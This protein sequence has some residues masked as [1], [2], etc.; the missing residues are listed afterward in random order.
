MQIASLDLCKD[1]Y[2]LSGWID[3]YLTYHLDVRSNEWCEP[4]HSEVFEHVLISLAE[5]KSTYKKDRV[6]PAY[7]LGYLL[8]KLPYGGFCLQRHPDPDGGWQA[9]LQDNLHRRI[10]DVYADTPEDAACKLAIELFR[11]GVLVKQEEEKTSE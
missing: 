1:L 6:R 9:Y 3:T 5:G 2:E 7:D 10:A 8:Q 11:H 4:V